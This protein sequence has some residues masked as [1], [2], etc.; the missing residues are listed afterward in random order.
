MFLFRHR[1]QIAQTGAQ[2]GEVVL[3]ALEFQREPAVVARFAQRLYTLP[4][5]YHAVADHRA[6]Q[7]IA[8]AG[9]EPLVA[10]LLALEQ[11]VLGVGVEGVLGGD[12]QRVRVK[13]EDGQEKLFAANAAPIVKVGK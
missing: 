7:E 5:G 12:G 3:H 2:G 1:A 13:F 9:G 4:D 10:G 11:E 8:V 6:A